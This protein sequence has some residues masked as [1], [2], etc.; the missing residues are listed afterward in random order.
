MVPFLLLNACADSST[1]DS[2]P[3]PVFNRIPD[4]KK[5][6]TFT[7]EQAA[8]FLNGA[9]LIGNRDA[10]ASREEFKSLYQKINLPNPG[11]LYAVSPELPINTQLPNH[12]RIYTSPEEMALTYSDKTPEQPLLILGFNFPTHKL[13]AYTSATPGRKMQQLN[14]KDRFDFTQF[15]GDS[16]LLQMAVRDNSNDQTHV[17]RSE[18]GLIT[19]LTGVPSTKDLLAVGQMMH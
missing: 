19:Y 2:T 13:A 7:D 3:V 15:Y 10:A 14:L 11:I 4:D 16:I 18:V 8:D 5:M 6:V 12:D 17:D 9:G 1:S